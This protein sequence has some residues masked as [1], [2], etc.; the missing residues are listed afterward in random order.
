MTPEEHTA[1]RRAYERRIEIN[2]DAMQKRGLA[3][4]LTLPPEVRQMIYKYLFDYSDTTEIIAR[5]YFVRPN[6]AKLHQVCR[7]L[8]AEIDEDFYTRQ[9]FTFKTIP[10]LDLWSKIHRDRL[11][12]MQRI[13]LCSSSPSIIVPFT[14]Q[15]P[16]LKILITERHKIEH[17]DFEADV[18][19][20][21]Q[22]DLATDDTFWTLDTLL[23]W[24]QPEAILEAIPRFRLGCV[25]YS[26]RKND[27]D[28]YRLRFCTDR[29]VAANTKTCEWTPINVQQLSKNIDE[30]ISQLELGRR[31][32]WDTCV[33]KFVKNKLG[34]SMKS[35]SI[36]TLKSLP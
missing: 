10:A 15:C 4:L 29:L 35:P 28:R 7:L 25:E 14:E 19:R 20:L 2:N 13:E 3:N 16:R 32:I 30:V 1:F 27:R 18:P 21:Y 36:A 24:R 34:R 6:D 9:T 8:K 5:K 31:R 22:L 17:Y 23:M 11:S 26:L 33:H 12:L